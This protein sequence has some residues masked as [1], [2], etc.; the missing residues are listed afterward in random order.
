[1]MRRGIA[2]AA[3]VTAVVV[4]GW[5]VTG[6]AALDIIKFL[7]YDAAF[8]ALPGIAL[9]WALRGHRSALLTTI[10]LGWPLGQALEMLAFTGTAEIGA[11]WLFLLYPV[12]VIV[13]SAY[14]VRRRQ[15]QPDDDIDADP[16]SGSERWSTAVMWTAAGA[17]SLALIYLTLE[18]LPLAPLPGSSVIVEY[19]DYPYFIGLITQ[20]M[21]HWPPT[22]PGLSGV[23]LAYEWFVLFHI[24]AASQVTHI[25]VPIIGLRLDYV[26]TIVVVGCQLL[27]VGRYV[28]RSAWTGVIALGLLFLMGPPDLTSS[29]SGSPDGVFVH[30][31]DSWTFPFGLTFMLALLYLI[32]ERLRAS[33]E[34]QRGDLRAWALITI[35]MI[36]ASG[37]KATILP[38]ITVG[39]A[40]YIAFHVLMRRRVPA[41]VVITLIL[42]IVVFVPTYI[43]VYGGQTPGTKIELLAWLA[44]STPVI[45]ANLIHHTAIRDL[46]LPFAYAAGFALV[47]APL[48]GVLYLLRRRHRGE[49][50]AFA[51]PI[52]MFAAGVLIAASVHHSSG[53]ELYFQDTGYVAACIVGAEGL[54]RAWLDLGRSVPV[55]R[56]A[57]ALAFAG[58]VVLILV[59]VRLT[60]HSVDT[61]GRIMLRYIGVV[62][63]GVAFVAACAV[64]VRRRYG[65]SNGI[66]ALGLIPIMAASIVTTPL[67]VYPNVQKVLADEPLTSTQIAL[68]PP[69]LAALYWLRDH[70]SVNDVFAVNNHWI[71]PEHT[72]AKYYYY[73]AFSQRQ[74]FIEAYNPYPIPPGPGT[75]AGANFIYRMQL[76]DEVF[77]RA[78]PSALKILTEDYGVRF[79]FI[80]RTMGPFLSAVLG[81]GHLVFSNQDADIVAVG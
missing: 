9:L 47:M 48:A 54:R 74:A 64:V 21:N 76:N 43:I 10:A 51:F 67:A 6:V 75:P 79:L 52:C 26:P 38:D 25:P 73:T 72:S 37:A 28:G 41:S 59:I 77:N 31:W 14:V 57:V 17:L 63:L 8:V 45:F 61:P 20:V 29:Y 19:P 68:K 56:S 12:V 4:I 69:L 40:I 58:W 65:S 80:D 42:G 2:P 60:S 71:N 46:V 39:A 23:P 66:V 44:G 27:A 35:L 5:L 13:P 18:F 55:S 49:I 1:M 16:E 36:G 30:L 50:H 53:S 24:A 22:T 62:I 7:A 34:R 32:T 70:S 81:L 15:T 33:P 3:L 78:D 11:R